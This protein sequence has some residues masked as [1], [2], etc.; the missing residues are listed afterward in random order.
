MNCMQSVN[1]SKSNKFILIVQDQIGA[2]ILW[3]VRIIFK[4]FYELK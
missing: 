4:P 3:I 1:A 2:Y